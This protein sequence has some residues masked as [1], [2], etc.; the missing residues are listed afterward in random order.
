MKKLLF[1]LLFLCMATSLPAETIDDLT[2]VTE[3]YPPFNFT[4]GEKRQGIATDTLIEMLKLSASN[5]TRADIAFLPWARAYNLAVNNRNV[6]LY[7]TT[8]TEAREKLFKW[9]GPILKSK[10]VLFARKDAHLKI[11]SVSDINERELNVGVVLHDVGEQMLLNQGLNRARLYRYHKGTDMVKMLHNN[12]IDLLA[13]GQIATHWFFQDQGYAPDDF[14]EVFFLQK[15][16]YYYALNKQTD[17][18]IVS[19]LQAAFD[20]VKESGK[21]EEIVRDYLVPCKP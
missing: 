2:I 19:Q 13:Y 6:L 14:E 1:T 10:F 4:T 15:S 16:D 18:K 20:Q 17:D 21:L 5:Q 11:D 7:S 8:R 3:E 12:R 9:V